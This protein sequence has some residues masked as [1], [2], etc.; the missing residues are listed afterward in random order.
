[1]KLRHRLLASA[2][3]AILVVG[4]GLV[5]S[6]G[7]PAQAHGVTMVP[8]SRTWLCYKDALR[9]NGQLIAYNPACAAAI[10]STG[11]TPLYNWFA[12]LRSD[13]GGRTTGYIPDGS[14]CSGG[15]GGPFDFSAYN[16]VRNDWPVTH[17][18]AGSTIQFQ[19]SN[20]AAHPGTFHVAITNNGWN[21]DGPLKWSD[22]TEIW[23][24]TDPP[25]TG[26]AG[27]LNYYYWNTTL[28][29]GKTGR[30]IIY[31]RWVRSDSQENF[32]SCSDVVFDGGNGQV[33]GVGPGGTTAPTTPAVT[34]PPVSTTAPGQT[35]PPPATTPPAAGSACT[36]TYTTT[37]SWS[38]GFQGD[39]KVTNPSASASLSGWTVKAT[40][41]DGQ[42][43]S[44]S[45]GST[46]SAAGSLVTFKPA[47][48]NS[49]LAAGASTSFG[50]LGTTTGS[51]TAPTV[52]CS[53]P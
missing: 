6:A 2:A 26:P 12:V 22:L 19:H 14:L 4:G 9:D 5:V 16:A 27:G 32:F 44:Q 3:A 40:F 18:T 41:A 37:S 13:A 47:T 49:S 43:V 36:A 23:S 42:T 35:T 51:V 53:S 48:W 30:H 28:P 52:T 10:A 1:V 8:G 34:T 33:T 46:F 39:V 25:S 21:P 29:A 50:L 31:V 38:N 24:S 15:T 20:W 7:S 45:W 17:L 11:T